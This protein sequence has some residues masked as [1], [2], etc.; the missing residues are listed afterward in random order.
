MQ[1]IFSLL[2]RLKNLPYEQ[3][4]V[5][6]Q[7]IQEKQGRPLSIRAFAEAAETSPRRIR[8][9]IRQGRLRTL[10]NQAGEVRIPEPTRCRFLCP[11]TKPP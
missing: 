9:L 10:E 7:A 4:L 11:A 5:M 1:N 2:E 3:M 6:L 8:R